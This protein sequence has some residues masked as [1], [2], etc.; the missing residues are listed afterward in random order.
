[1]KLLGQAVKHKKF[2]N[3]VITEHSENKITVCFGKT[4]KMFIFPDAFSQYLELKDKLL[5]E[6]IDQINKERIQRL[7]VKNLKL[8]KENKYRNR[9]YSMKIPAK[10]QI[11]YDF[12]EGDM[13]LVEYVDTGLDRK[14]VV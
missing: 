4:E 12:S 7:E 11:V 2:G 3:G 14:S 10:S 5:Q 6:K 13:N 8:K 9:M 1:M